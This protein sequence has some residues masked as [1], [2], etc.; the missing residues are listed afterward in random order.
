MLMQSVIQARSVSRDIPPLCSRTP[1]R[2]IESMGFSVSYGPNAEIYGD[3]EQA[4]YLYKVVRGTVRTSKILEDGRRQIAAFYVPGD[5][6]GLES[7]D[8][9]TLSAEAVG[10]CKLLLIQRSTL[11]AL[12][13]RDSKVARELWT[14]TAAELQRAQEHSLLLTKSALTRVAG[15]LVEMAERFA[16]EDEVELP[17][18]R[19]D[20]A[21]YLALTVETVSRSLTQLEDI[22]AIQI[23]SR[24][25]IAFRNHS[26]LVQFGA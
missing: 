21:D 24:R 22:A 11:V 5:L 9:R 10:Q 6:F 25:G 2:S 1:A 19:Q 8:H 18:G 20:I 13:E 23:T 12:A 14:L 15:F 16:S 17:M 7:R 26:A 4:K 3:Q